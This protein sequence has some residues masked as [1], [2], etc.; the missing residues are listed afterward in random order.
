M[1]ALVLAHVQP[2]Q[3]ILAAKEIFGQCFGQL[4]LTYPGGPYEKEHAQRAPWIVQLR[5]HQRHDVN[6]GPDRLFLA[7][8]A[9]IEVGANLRLAQRDGIG[10]DAFPVDR[11][12]ERR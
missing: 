8:H 10:D 2:D 11:S 5:F 12:C 1:S 9:L 3:F 6:H 7:D 4:G